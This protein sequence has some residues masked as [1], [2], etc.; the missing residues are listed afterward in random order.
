MRRRGT[1][2]RHLSLSHARGSQPQVFTADEV[3]ACN[4]AV[5]ARSSNFQV[6]GRAGRACG[7]VRRHSLLYQ[8]ERTGK[9]RLGGT[10]P[11]M[12]GDGTTGRQDLG[13]L[14]AWRDAPALREMLC[15]PRL[16]PYYAELCGG[17]GYRLDHSP[18]VLQQAPGADGF[19]MHGGAIDDLGRYDYE[20]S[21]ACQGGRM[22]CAL[23]AAS[24]CLTDTAAGDGG[25]VV[26]PGSHKSNFLCPQSIKEHRVAKEYAVQP[27]TKAGDVVLF[28]EA[29]TH[30][31]L[32]WQGPVTRR[33]ALYRFA[34]ATQAYGRAYL[35]HEDT[36]PAEYSEGM[37]QAQKAVLAAP[38]HTRLDRPAPAADG[39]GVVTPESRAGFKKEFDSKVFGTTY[40]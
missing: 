33:L 34:P 31:T 1:D 40:F 10:E 6:R 35:R 16:Q 25:F 2:T 22:R 13:G 12:A 27:V 3:A 4:A 15:H 11:S 36:W 8:Q 21:Y 28:S 20:L 37:S 19:V 39:Q 18:F 26:L 7:A 30:G 9:L 23:L 5:D 17:N 32:A 14:L 29:M 38:Y 24:L